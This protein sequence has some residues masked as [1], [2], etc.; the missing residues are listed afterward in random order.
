MSG[1]RKGP[2][3]AH[4]ESIPNLA[5][6]VDI[7]MCLL[8]YFMLGAA[9][10]LNTEGVLQTELDDR[11]G[12]AKGESVQIN[13][14]IRIGLQDV[15][16]GQSCTIFVQEDSLSPNTFD[17]LRT[18]MLQKRQAGADPANP[19]IVGAEGTVRYK[20]IIKAFDACVRAGFKNVQF[21]VSFAGEGGSEGGQTK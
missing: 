20:F 9:M 8:I 10:H 5:P 19:V 14:V 12:P 21:S 16:Q 3:K 2:P 15:D 11:S 18:F 7:I 13:P 1:T 4:G 17:Q 6:M